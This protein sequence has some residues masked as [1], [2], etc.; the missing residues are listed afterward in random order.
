MSIKTYTYSPWGSLLMLASTPI[1][2]LLMFRSFHTANI[3]FFVFCIVGIP[4]VIWQSSVF[5]FLEAH[6]DDI[7]IKLRS[8]NARPLR[9]LRWADIDRVVDDSPFPW[10]RATRIFHLIPKWNVYERP[11][12]RI[13][14]TT[15]FH[16][17]RDLLK[18]V[19]W[20]VSPDTKVDA[21]VLHLTG[22]TSQD[23][24]RL[25]QRQTAS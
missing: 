18:E 8:K 12:K 17:Y 24:G 7:T 1:G 13:T 23:I 19:V 9:E 21:R 22:L 4:L 2:V 14:L 16:H 15:H 5:F 10:W 3:G 11:K 6:L 25:Y 20:R